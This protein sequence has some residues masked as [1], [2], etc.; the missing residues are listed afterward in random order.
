MIDAH[1][2]LLAG[3]DDGAKDIEETPKICRMAADD[4]IRVIVATPNSFDGEFLNH[5]DA[6]RTLVRGLT[7]SLASIG[8]NATIMPGMEVRVS[9]DLPQLLAD[10][11]VLTLNEEDNIIVEFHRFQIPT[12]F[13]N[14]DRKLASLGYSLV[15][16]HPELNPMIQSTPRITLQVVR[17]IQTVGVSRPGVSGQLDRREWV[18]GEKNRHHT[19]QEQSGPHY[20]ERRSLV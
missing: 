8:L 13:E 1:N 16:G 14:L 17:G 3:T 5:V 19:S 15:L 9:A 18:L 6:V 2:H 12:G 7:T 11:K 20:C 10:G 4:W